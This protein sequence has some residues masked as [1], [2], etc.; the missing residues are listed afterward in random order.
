[1]NQDQQVQLK[2]ILV[3]AVWPAVVGG[4]VVAA[5]SLIAYFLQ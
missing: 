2:Y 4:L 5:V 3:F 1:M